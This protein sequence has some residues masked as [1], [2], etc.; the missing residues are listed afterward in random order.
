MNTFKQ[1]TL[2]SKDIPSIYSIIIVLVDSSCSLEYLLLFTQLLG[3][4]YEDL[5]DSKL[6]TEFTENHVEWILLQALPRLIQS[7]LE[8]G[9]YQDLLYDLTCQFLLGCSVHCK[10]VIAVKHTLYPFVYA[11]LKQGNVEQKRFLD[12]FSNW[13]FSSSLREEPESESIVHYSILSHFLFMLNS[14]YVSVFRLSIRS[15]EEMLQAI[16]KLTSQLK[17]TEVIDYDPNNPQVPSSKHTRL[18]D[19]LVYESLV[20][21]YTHFKHQAIIDLITTLLFREIEY[22]SFGSSICC[23]LDSLV[24]QGESVEQILSGLIDRILSHSFIPSPTKYCNVKMLVS[25]VEELGVVSSMSYATYKM[26]STEQLVSGQPL[27]HES[28]LPLLERCDSVDVSILPDP[29]IYVPF[30]LIILRSLKQAVEDDGTTVSFLISKV[31][32]CIDHFPKESC[33]YACCMTCYMQ[34]V[35]HCVLLNPVHPLLRSE[36]SS[37]QAFLNESPGTADLASS[38]CQVY[39][40]NRPL[41]SYQPTELNPAVSKKDSPIAF[42]GKE[43]EQSL[44]KQLDMNHQG[45]LYLAATA[46]KTG[47]ETSPLH[48]QKCSYYV[49]DPHLSGDGARHKLMKVIRPIGSYLSAQESH[50]LGA[51]AD[52]QNTSSSLSLYSSL[53]LRN[54]PVIEE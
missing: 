24:K 46:K 20:S 48:L 35:Q 19:C 37:I 14:V 31:R 10:S 22:A 7:P 50:S 17:E 27:L 3:K 32:F 54:R 11:A 47:L 18:F 51:C 42:Y 26:E 5:S 49:V 30:C 28:I 4:H 23:V 15:I 40:R 13:L 41:R 16:Y 43:L 44:K 6:A 38:F 34:T 12:M 36:L 45:W 39:S 25:C 2:S 8:K 52:V 1:F 21:L 9:M 29:S 33:E 53:R